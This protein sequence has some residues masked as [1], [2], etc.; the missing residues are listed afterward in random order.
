MTSIAEIMARSQ[1]IIDWQHNEDVLRVMRRDMKRE[2]RALG[3]LSEEQ[4]NELVTSMVEIARRKRI[5]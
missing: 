2:L 5:Q 4:L 3:N 1:A